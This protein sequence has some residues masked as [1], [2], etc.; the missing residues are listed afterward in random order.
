[1]LRTNG[2]TKRLDSWKEIATYLRRG[3]RT[4]RRWERQEGLPVRRHIHGKQ[5]TV[6]AFAPDIDKWLD[7]RQTHAV[8]E[9]QALAR[10]PR[11]YATHRPEAIL[12]KHRNRPAVIAVLPLRNLG[13]PEQER[14]ADG[15]TDE[16][17]TEIG[18]C[19]PTQLRVIAMT[20]V[21]QYKHSSK[22]IAQIGQER[23]EPRR[24]A[25]TA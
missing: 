13:G 9:G 14:F 15:L 18:H 16:L 3:V 7:G 5:A 21:M 2:Q 1:M 6:Y 22:S 25:Q 17:I 23:V 24:A 4:V 12:A 11:P 10:S 8:T 19:C 20:S